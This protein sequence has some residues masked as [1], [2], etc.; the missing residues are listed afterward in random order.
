MIRTANTAAL[1]AAFLVLTGCGKKAPPDSNT[2]GQAASSAQPMSPPVGPVIRAEQV[3]K[4][5]VTDSAAADQKYK[6][7]DLHVEGVIIQADTDA[8][9]R[10]YVLLEGGQSG[11][12]PVMVRC[13]IAENDPQRAQKASWT[14][15]KKITLSGKCYGYSLMVIFTDCRIISVSAPDAQITMD[16]LSKEI[17]ASGN[18]VKLTKL[19]FKVED[20]PLTIDVPE[21]VEVKKSLSDIDISQGLKFILRVSLGRREFADHSAFRADAR[22]LIRTN[23]LFLSRDAHSFT[24]AMAVK[25]GP[26]DF[27]LQNHRF[28][29][30]RMVEQTRADC[31]FMMKCARTLAR[32]TPAATE[33]REV[34]KE[35]D[36]A[37]EETDGRVTKVGFKFSRGTDSTLDVLSNFPDVEELTLGFAFTDDGLVHLRPLKK[38]R[39]LSLATSGVSD[40]GLRQVAEIQTL[41]VLD[42][43]D[44]R[45]TDKGMPEL[46]RLKGLEELDLSKS[47]VTAAGIMELKAALPQ[48]K[49]THTVAGADSRVPQPAPSSRTDY[50]SSSGE[51]CKLFSIATRRSVSVQ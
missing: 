41:K 8:A 37:F 22:M 31:L 25:L 39:M 43:S 36:A 5:Y 3:A 10:D 21:G 9:G 30:L 16:A 44:A 32:K 12:L 18:G 51:G 6:D 42:L 28:V 40:K 38:L 29:E 35:V 2:P 20:V 17:E 46:A 45:I 24:F 19:D 23:D 7:N 50:S 49:I 27:T 15:G 11:N 48:L 33:A 47:D 14:K 34:L 1:L 13:L 4:E 26:Q